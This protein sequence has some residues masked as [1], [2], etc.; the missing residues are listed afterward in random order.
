[1]STK[2]R[3]KPK[4]VRPDFFFVIE[5]KYITCCI[6][7]GLLSYVRSEEIFI[8][9]IYPLCRSRMKRWYPPDFLHCIT[10]LLYYSFFSHIYKTYYLFLLDSNFCLSFYLCTYEF[11]HKECNHHYY[12]DIILFS[13]FEIERLS[14]CLTV[15]SF[16]S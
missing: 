13:F 1:M 16:T 7:N 5:P 15:Y 11:I 12:G 10:K 14:N 2:L 4:M 3:P 6:F 9:L 8:S